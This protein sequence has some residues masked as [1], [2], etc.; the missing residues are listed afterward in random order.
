V[1]FVIPWIAAPVIDVAAAAAKSL[2]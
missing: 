1:L 2:Y